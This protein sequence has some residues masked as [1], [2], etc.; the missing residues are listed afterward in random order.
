MKKIK[1]TITSVLILVLFL[2]INT[3]CFGVEKVYKGSKSEVDATYIDEGYI[4]VKYLNATDKKLKVIIQKDST[5]YTYDLNNRGE[6]DTLPL[7]M[8]NGK[9]KISIFENISN[10]K[11]SVKQTVNV[12]VKL[13]DENS[14]FLVKN[15]L[16]NFS[17]T[18]DTVKK[19]QELTEGKTDDIEKI[20]VIYDYIISNIVYDTEKAKNVQSGYLPKIDEVLKSN[21]G[22]CYDYASVMAS[23]LRSQSIPT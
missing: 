7:Q 15:Q 18:S 4:N 6:V 1:I 17:D 23:M 2:A 21:K 10:N 19:A 9:Y 3:T 8:G 20:G 5:K 14:P 16:V 22:I 11:Y 13:N 12:D